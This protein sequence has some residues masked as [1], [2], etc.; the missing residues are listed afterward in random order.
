MSHQRI[1]ILALEIAD[2]DDPTFD[3]RPIFLCLHHLYHSM[4]RVSIIILLCNGQRFTSDL[5]VRD[6]FDG[7]VRSEIERLNDLFKK[8]TALKTESQISGV[9]LQP[10]SLL[11]A[12]S[13]QGRS[14]LK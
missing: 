11:P 4:A 1:C 5:E 2:N 14:L 9:P 10:Q 8:E 12:D 3:L 13:L 7:E 6:S